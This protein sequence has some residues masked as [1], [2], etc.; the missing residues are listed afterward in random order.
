MKTVYIVFEISWRGTFVSAVFENEA[1]AK[2][3]LYEL[4]GEDYDLGNA[5]EY[6][7]QEWEV[8]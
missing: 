1:D 5:Y 7:I 3:Y 8:K 2:A 4:C 6:F